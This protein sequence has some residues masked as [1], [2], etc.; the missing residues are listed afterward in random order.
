MDTSISSW[1]LL[2]FILGL[3]VSLF[4]VYS[5]L[6]TK[7]LEDDDRTEKAQNELILLMLKVIK[8]NKGAIDEDQLFL[9]MTKDESFNSKLFW[10]FNLN[11]LNHLLRTY[12]LKNVECSSIKDIY[13]KISS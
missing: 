5:F 12:Y 4:K 9:S 8:E 1:M 11:R 2:F 7:Q 3:A 10:R 6:P 13:K